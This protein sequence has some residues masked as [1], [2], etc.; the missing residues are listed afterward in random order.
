MSATL[1]EVLRTFGPAYPNPHALSTVQARAW[2]AIVTC[3]TPALG[4]T[5]QQCDHC[6]RE[7]RLFRSCGNR[8]C[9]QCQAFESQRW[10]DQQLQRLV[11]GEYFMLTFTLPAEFRALAW[12]NQRELYE[13]IIASA[14]ATANTFSHNQ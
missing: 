14:W 4:G 7:Q 9:P 12:H 3:R 1:A 5:L 6:G 11:P 8:H 2:R 13:L 10:I